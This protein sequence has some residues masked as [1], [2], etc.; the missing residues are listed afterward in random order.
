MAHRIFFW[1][2]RTILKVQIL[3]VGTCSAPYSCGQ[4]KLL[5]HAM[6]FSCWRRVTVALGASMLYSSFGEKMLDTRHGRD[7]CLDVGD[8]WSRRFFQCCT[9]RLSCWRHSLSRH[10]FYL[11]ATRC[12]CNRNHPGLEKTTMLVP[13]VPHIALATSCWWDFTSFFFPLSCIDLILA[14]SPKSHVSKNHQSYNFT[15]MYGA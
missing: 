3:N 14:K 7:R 13:A 10:D 8:I 2:I 1:E 9:M 6:N 15:C 5:V 11:L 12:H 4:H